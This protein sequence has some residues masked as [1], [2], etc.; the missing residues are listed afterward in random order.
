MRIFNRDHEQLTFDN[1]LEEPELDYS[2]KKDH[3]EK[4][5][6][7][8]LK[9][10]RNTF[11]IQLVA[12]FSQFI[13]YLE[14]HQIRLTKTMEYISRKHLPSINEKL[15]V[16]SANATSYAQQENYPYIH[17]FYHLAL[18]GHLIEKV[19][20]ESNQPKLKV[21]ERWNMFKELTDAEQYFFL[22]ETFWV[23]LNWTR[24]IH[25]S[26]N[27]IHQILPD[28]FTKLMDEKSGNYLDLGK[29]TLLANLT[30]QWNYF[31]L[32]FEWFGIWVC[33]KDLESTN[34]YGKKSYYFVKSV[35]LTS[36][37]KKVIPILLTSRSL[38]AWNIPLRRE[39]GEVN[40]IPGSKLPETQ[41]RHLQKAHKNHSPQS[42][43]QAFTGLFPQKDLQ[44]TLPRVER[45]YTDGAHTFKVAFDKNSWCKI[46]LSSKNTMEDLHK[47]I[48]K[49]FDFDDDHLYSF[50]MDGRKWSQDCIVS[51]YDDSGAPN[52]AEVTIGSVGLT[53][54][55]RFMYLFD[56]GDEWTFTVTVEKIQESDPEPVAPH[57]TEKHG[58][59]PEQYFY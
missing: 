34:H 48:L 40:P 36:F 3:S 30:F 6:D 42:F 16:K 10:R 8:T 9:K 54:G 20:V 44:N 53:N 43:Y 51:P 4:N 17:F 38:Q 56:F 39:H 28:I 55:R 1:L 57:I 52:A 12:D 45:K 31:F 23:D 11:P 41:D 50:F 22:F 27:P 49:A 33:E 21:T 37:G 35:T 15:S 25:K 58:Y 46:I 24:L 29:N 5:E 47:V 13:N 14:H 18:S 7:W 26:R 32:Y 59:G 19:S 2:E